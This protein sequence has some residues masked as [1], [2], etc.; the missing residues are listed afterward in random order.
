LLFGDVLLHF[1]VPMNTKEILRIW[2][3]RTTECSECGNAHYIANLNS[4]EEKFKKK[5]KP[6]KCHLPI[7]P[8]DLKQG[9]RGY[10]GSY[11]E[12]NHTVDVYDFDINSRT[13]VIDLFKRSKKEKE[14]SEEKL[15]EEEIEAQFIYDDIDFEEQE[16]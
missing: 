15:I 12:E 10:I 6:M 11:E 3:N 2:N 13:Y 5:L 9:C 7:H 8:K 14:D 16:Y 4:L 1:A